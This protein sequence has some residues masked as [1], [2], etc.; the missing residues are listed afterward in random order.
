[1][2]TPAPPESPDAHGPSDGEPEDD[3]IIGRT[4]RRAVFVLVGVG[5]VAAA[6]VALW[7]RPAPPAASPVAPPPSAPVPATRAPTSAPPLTFTDVGAAAGLAFD[8][9]NGARGARLLP[10]TMGGG[11]T[12]FDHDGDGDPDLLALHGRAWPDDPAPPVPPTPSLFRNDG[13]H[14]TNIS[15]EAGLNTPMQGMGA[16]AA[17]V[18]GD[19]HPDLLFTGVDGARFLRGAGGRYV[20]TTDAAGLGA[21]GKGWTTAAV[22]FDA[23]GDGDLDLAV[24]RYV[25][26]SRAV[27]LGIESTLDGRHRAYGPPTQFEGTHLH[28]FRN[29]GAGHFTDVG[30][31]AGLEVN[32]PATGRPLAK[33]LG[34]TAA[35]VDFD[36]RLDLIAANDTVQNLLF[37]NRGGGRFEEQGVALGL[38]FDAGG[39][40]RG[41][42]G[43]DAADFADDGRLGVAIGNFANEMVALYTRAPGAAPFVDTAIAAGLGGPTRRPLKFGLFFFDADLDGR[44]DLL[45]TNGHLEP[46]IGRFQPGQTYEQAPMLFWQRAPGDGGPLFVERPAE[47]L[48]D[49]GRP[50]VGRGAA[51]ADIDADGDLDVALARPAGPITLLRNDQR[52]GHHW[53]RVRLRGAPANRDA[54]GAVVSVTAGGRT[55]RRMVMPYRSYLSQVEATLTFGLGSAP[56]VDAVQIRWPDGREQ[57]VP[58]ASV[59]IDRRLDVDAR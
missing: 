36:G 39:R 47:T 50:L 57:T 16:Y 5:L 13:G 24:A 48:G 6:A 8:R 10:E 55:Q 11:V 1:M 31:A 27:D 42:M 43:I 12:F 21:L 14:F 9:F 30:R 28:L 46:E 37:V 34:L 17:D 20:D 59:G 33:T 23:D 56:R 40:A 38:A 49:F 53:L 51:F 44:L 45:L 15:A 26:W 18:D 25:Q 19:G 29:D 22:F 4:F 52:T 32:N 2:N 41:A 3:A 58:G 7:P 54:I 35:D